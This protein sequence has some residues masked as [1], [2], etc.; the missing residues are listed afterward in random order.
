AAALKIEV[1]ADGEVTQ[2]PM[3]LEAVLLRIAQ[4]AVGNVAKH[5]QATRARITVSY[6]DDAVRVDI[7]D[8]GVGFDVKAVE[9]RPAGLGHIGRAAMKRRAG[10]VSGEVVIESRPGNGRAV[11]RNVPIPT[12]AQ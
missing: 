11:R 12:T 5:A 4:G 3:K 2:L 6:S 7:V 1:A 10:E 9:S 8:N